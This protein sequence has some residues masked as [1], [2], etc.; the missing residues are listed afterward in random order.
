VY[1][2]ISQNVIEYQAIYQNPGISSVKEKESKL[3]KKK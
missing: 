2:F 1:S 3:E